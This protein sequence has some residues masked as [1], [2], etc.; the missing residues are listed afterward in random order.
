M[1]FVSVVA[2]PRLLCRFLAL[3]LLAL[4][5][6][7]APALAATI[8]VDDLNDGQP[9]SGTSVDPYRDLQNAIDH[10]LSGDT[11][12]IRAGRYVA[13]PTEFIDPTCGNCPP[14]EFWQD[15]YA[16]YGFRI[17][18]KSLTLRGES[19]KNT[20]L[21]TGAG[22]GVLFENAGTSRLDT[23]RITGGV[24]DWDS[25][26]TNAAVVARWTNLTLRSVDIVNNTN[27]W[28]GEGESVVAGIG[29][30]FGREG[31]SIN[32]SSLWIYNNGWDGIALYRGAPEIPNS[33]ARATITKTDI[34]YGRGVGIGVTW[35][36][37]ADIT[38]TRI[39]HYW[40]GVGSFGSS[41]VS[42][43][44][45]VVRDQIGWGV[46]ADGTSSMTAVNNVIARQGR[47]GLSQWSSGATVVFTNN[48]VYD[49]GWN[50]DFEVG[51]RVGI[52]L[53]NLSRATVTYNDIVVH[54]FGNACFGTGCTPY[55]LTGIHGNISAD[56]QFVDSL[57][58]NFALQCGSQAINAGDVFLS[59]VDGS[60]SDMG[61]Y[62]GPGSAQAP[63]CF[64]PDLQPTAIVVSPSNPEA[65]DVLRFDSA[66]RNAA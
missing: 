31:A 5:S 50:P 1:R 57:A 48:I 29:G 32:A 63:S 27:R 35:D 22:Y 37:Q 14:E 21:E 4:L 43:R 2:S 59:D 45:S 49:N 42:L 15:I 33:G 39:S 26:A 36:A 3:A 23:V 53:N 25:R 24:R 52:W 56:P 18:N 11:V 17:A 16:T 65:G 54:P 34:E 61:V 10:A 40:K 44:N 20:V 66:V 62:G 30:L 41:R 51:P 6:A 8:Y 58:N 55:N 9:G 19:R 60:R 28:E 46:I 12:F 13:T 38:N 7:S 64:L 47:S